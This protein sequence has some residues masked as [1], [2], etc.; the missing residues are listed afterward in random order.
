MQTGDDEVD[1]DEIEHDDGE[2]TDTE[3]SRFRPCPATLDPHMQIIDIDEH[4]DERP[5]FFRVPAPET[6][7]GDLG[8]N[9]GE[10][11]TTENEHRQADGD[12]PV[13]DFVSEVEVDLLRERL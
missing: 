1:E 11:E 7:P 13:T 10:D 6:V 4:R 9:H 5:H 12:R 8:P 3:P 2:S